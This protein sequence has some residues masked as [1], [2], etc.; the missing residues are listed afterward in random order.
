MIRIA[1]YGKGGIGKSTTVS[2]VAVALAEKGMKVMQ[3]G[4]DPKADST[5]LL[6]HGKE[7]STVLDLYNKKRQDLKLEDMVQIGYGGVVCVEAGGPAPGLGCAGRGIITALEKLQETGAYETYKP[8][9][10][11]YDVLGDVV[12]GGF[13]MPMRKGYAD[14]VFIITSGENMAI[15]AGAN[16]AMAVENFR[17]RGYAS[18]GGIILNRRNVPR[19][20]EKVQE[21]A[22]DFHTKVIGTL[23]R[24]ELVQEAEVLGKTLLE[25]YP[26]SEMAEEYRTLA[27]QI[28]EACREEAPC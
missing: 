1:V 6:R 16:I 25:V 12:C 5:I 23:S 18:L 28:L 2:N 13:S 20:E 27:E 21:L 17:N 4:C 19:E 15:H 24:S 26:D 10:V 14:K 7:A 22:E 9:I 8:D 11:F 3:I